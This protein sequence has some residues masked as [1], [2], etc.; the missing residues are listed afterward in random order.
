M[1]G[2]TGRSAASLV[3][4]GCLLWA[5]NDV[6]SWPFL[7][8]VAA[9]PQVGFEPFADENY[10]WHVVLIGYLSTRMTF[11]LVTDELPSSSVFKQDA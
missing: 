6:A 3:A 1:A 2:M 5:V 4:V 8:L 10:R 7:D 11:Y 9:S